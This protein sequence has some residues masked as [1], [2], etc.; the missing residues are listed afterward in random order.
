MVA[1]DLL[2]DLQ[3][4][5]AVDED[6]RLFGQH[7]RRSGRA[8]KAGQPRQPLRIAADIF[9]HML[10]GQ[11]NDEAV[12]P[13]GLELLAKGLEAIGVGGHALT[14]LRVS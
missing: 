6:R 12:E 3:S 5:A 8:L 7:D 9:A 4:V 11:R 10:V 2:A 1:V 14:P 13:V